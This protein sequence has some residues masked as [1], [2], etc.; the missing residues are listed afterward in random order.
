MSGQESHT[1]DESTKYYCQCEDAFVSTDTSSLYF[2]GL[3]IL[4]TGFKMALLEKTII[5]GSCWNYINEIYTRAGFSDK[6][7]TIYRS[8]KG[9]PYA[10]A[11]LVQ[12]GD[13][14]YHVNH[15][16]N[17][18]EHSA[19]FICWKDFNK[20][21]AITLSYAGMNRR[22]PGKYGEYQLN[23]IYS[24]FRPSVINIKTR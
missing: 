22:V 9:G 24:I 17:G 18:V 10:D 7:E 3:K 4:E 11:K 8:K 21:I 1:E 12:P 15:Q 5:V 13:W 6:K 14:I 16:Y 20:R 23:S 2:S 19:I